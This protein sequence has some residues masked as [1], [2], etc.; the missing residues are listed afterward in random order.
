VER[1]QILRPQISVNLKQAE[2]LAEL[3]IAPPEELE[4]ALM[5]LFNNAADAS[6]AQVEISAAYEADQLRIAIADRGPGFSADQKALAGRVLFTGKP[7]QGMGLGLT[8]TH[9]TVERLGG[10][11]VLTERAGGGA[12]VSVGLPLAPLR[13]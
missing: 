1:W 2:N 4:Q 5:N 10:E 9:A 12:R 11:V 3:E 6:P 8:L 7:G 13:P